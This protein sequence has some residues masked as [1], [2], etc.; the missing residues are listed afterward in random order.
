VK[1]PD[2]SHA[3]FDY[4]A[5]FDGNP[6][7]ILVFDSE[8]LRIV[9]ANDAALLAYGYAR[10]EFL[11][12]TIEDIRPPEDL[13]H[14]RECLA[15]RDKGYPGGKT[16]RHRKRD[17]TIME[18]QVF[19]LAVQFAG[20]RARLSIIQDVSHQRRLEEQL[21]HSQKLEAA[22]LLAGGIAHDF[23]NLLSI[24]LGSS[25]LARR[26][27]GA[28]RSPAEELESISSAASRA[29]ELTRKLLAFSR[30]QVMKM[31]P[32]EL[33]Q[34]LAEFARLLQRVV[35]EDIAL[36][37]RASAS[38]LVVRADTSQL[39]QV[40]LNLC[41][42]ARHAMP[43]GGRL[44]IET[45]R[46]AFD[47]D[48]VQRNPWARVGEYAELRVSDS[49]EGMDEP[50][51]RHIFEPF[52]TTKKDGTGLGLAVVHGIVQQHEGCVDVESAPGAGTTMHVYLPL[53]QEGP[54]TEVAHG[55]AGTLPRRG[56][57]LVLVAEDERPLRNL[58]S[59]SLKE[60][61][62]EVLT[63]ADGEEATRV[64]E[65]NRGRIAVVILDVV[66]PKL[67]GPEALARMRAIDPN[68]RAVLTTG[69][70]PDSDYLSELAEAESLT[71][72][73]K[74]FALDELGRKVREMLDV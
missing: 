51:R 33:N 6:S 60:L 16:S 8:T 49:G 32:L 67:G 39:E 61:G 25:E 27:V 68:V 2:A 19:G 73:P 23:N 15:N 65:A 29:A 24:V 53:T 9:D 7:P 17:G 72:L 31:R 71:V 20:R 30:K 36:E 42:N 57:E 22:G 48:F 59:L 26:A 58:I 63:A 44:V 3:A 47:E 11:G 14:L 46:A 10:E 55:E 28:G 21:R 45:Q 12:L 74:P 69:Y 37:F 70:A 50:T 43:K 62:Y 5:L 56:H 35:G 34:A 52:F 54:P 64:F 40:L 41:T 4:R 1:T 18:V 13:A 66:M 38:P